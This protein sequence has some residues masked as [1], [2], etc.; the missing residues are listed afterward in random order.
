M[1]K[2]FLQ[3]I[4]KNLYYKKVNTINIKKQYLHLKD[5]LSI[6]ILIPT[7]IG[8]IWQLLELS[9]I[10]T[11]FIRFFSLSQLVADGIL[12]LF[13]FTVFYFSFKLSIKMIGKQN[14]KIDL[15][16]K[17][18]SVWLSI[19]LV[20]CTLIAFYLLILPLLESI[21]IKRKITIIEITILIPILMMTIG[22]FLLG[23][24]GILENILH[25]N[26]Q[27]VKLWLIKIKNMDRLK[28]N[29]SS[30]VSA[31]IVLIFLFLIKFILVD[32]NPYMSNF[33]EYIIFPNNLLN[34]EVLENKII[35]KYSLKFKPRM[36]YNNDKYFFYKIID[37]KKNEKIL[38]IDYS[39]LTEE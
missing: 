20:G 17:P 23:I 10:S 26:T 18:N 13:I 24:L 3:Q 5:N 4:L 16:E 31:I 19:F 9:S 34:K 12:V 1:I 8:G 25:Q 7:L 11:S 33:R 35:K 28:N 30:L 21:Y 32:L 27:K 14:F 22:G 15:N 29:I 2:E 6:I 39:R 37:A 36:L 38:I